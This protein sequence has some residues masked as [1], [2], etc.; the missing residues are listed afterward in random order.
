MINLETL[1]TFL[2][3]CTVINFGLLLFTTVML[4]LFRDFVAGIHGK[5][6]A[7]PREELNPAYFSYLANFKI[8]II[9]F[10]LAPYVALKVIS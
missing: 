4:F 6:M 10:N 5:M 3:W 2:G 8:L 1:T 7:M 9:V